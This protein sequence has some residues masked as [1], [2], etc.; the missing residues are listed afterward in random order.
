[1]TSNPLLQ[2]PFSGIIPPMVTPLLDDN[3]IDKVGLERLIEHLIQGGV[4]GIF[5]LGTTGE[6]PSLPY[7]LRR[8][9]VKLTCEQ[10]DG[11]I[12]IM[13]GVTDSSPAESLRLAE[14]SSEVGASA[15]VAAPPYYFGLDQSEL[16]EYYLSLAERLP[17]PLYLYNMPSHTKIAI[18]IGAV[19]TL[20]KHPN[21]IGL[22]D[23]SGNAVYFNG[24]LHAMKED[25][26]FS[27]LVGPEEM[28]ASSV[29][30]GGH[31]GVNGGANL[32]PMLYVEL[33][34]AAVD[35]NHGKVMRLQRKVM[36]I[37]KRLYGVGK[38]GSS[39]LQGL[40]AGLRV[41]GICNDHL[42]SPLRGFEDP[43][44]TQIKEHLRHLQ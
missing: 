21:I 43:E 41:L 25:P 23:S 37:S 6:A 9:L 2:Q 32:F 30:M 18:S 33:Y 14:F 44:K 26:S 42:S 3:T 19:E 5:V 27:L 17:L 15:A 8:E 7:S 10:V 11:R 38:T 36:E 29:L 16:V 40:K 13:V 4:H 20:S 39:Y 31:G 12:P 35:R 24:V 28:M 22:K 1:M 34:Q